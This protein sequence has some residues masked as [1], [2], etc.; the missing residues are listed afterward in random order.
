MRF[1]AVSDFLAIIVFAIAAPAQHSDC[2]LSD[3][4]HLSP[5]RQQKFDALLRSTP[6]QAAV[7]YSLAMDY[8]Q[9]GNTR[10]ALD[11]LQRATLQ[12]PWLDPSQ[13]PV[14][15]AL[16]DCDAFRKIVARVEQKY[17]PMNASR[18]AHTIPSPDLI[19][20]G[21][22][23][24]PADGSLYVS[25]IYHRKILKITPSG[26][27][28][29]FVSKGQDGLLSVLGIKV[30]PRDRSV[31]AASEFKGAS[32]LFHFDRHGKT[33]AKYAPAQAGK[34]LFN[35]LVVAANGDVF[36]TDSSDGSIY[37]MPAGKQQLERLG[38]GDRL[39]PNGIAFSADEKRLYVAYAFG[40]AVMGRN[41]ES[42]SE[43]H[44]PSDISLA[45]FDGLYF[46][47][48]SLIGIQNGLGANRIVE[49][50]L[51]PDGNRVT[52]GR[53]LEFRSSYMELPTTGTIYNNQFFYMVNTQIDHEDGGALL[54]R[55]EL[56]PVRIAVMSLSDFPSPH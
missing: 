51:S 34:H 7:R 33:L 55:E 6:D 48:G 22:A 29:D 40:I 50:Q 14:F 10:R 3:S 13:E 54:H 25:S 41:G 15:A 17:P 28:T 24:D 31:W 19:P 43:L 9:A 20:E 12:V 11:E 1:L 21:I 32:L 5:A 44:A 26:N 39:Y 46:D 16:R 37:K 56:Q 42:I 52:A 47:R 27:I 30:D 23:S 45:Q 35:D 8:A 53:L 49:L 2:K 18:L 36:V 4:G 38:L